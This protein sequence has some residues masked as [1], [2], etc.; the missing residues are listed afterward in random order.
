MTPAEL[1]SLADDIEK[2]CED[3]ETLDF[4]MSVLNWLT[5]DDKDLPANRIKFL[6]D[7]LLEIA[8]CLERSEDDRVALDL[9]DLNA[10]LA[11]KYCKAVGR[12]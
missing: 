4:V 12:C 2:D 11:A 10:M 7:Q 8:D 1:S 9:M 5:D 6:G 3:L